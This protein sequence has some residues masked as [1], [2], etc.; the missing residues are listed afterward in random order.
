[1]SAQI[2]IQHD[3]QSRAYYRRK[4][5]EGKKHHG[6]VLALLGCLHVAADAD[7]TRPAC[8]ARRPRD[9]TGPLRPQRSRASRDPH[10]SRGPPRRPPARARSATGAARCANGW[11]GRRLATNRSCRR[12]CLT[13]SDRVEHLTIGGPKSRVPVP[14]APLGERSGDLTPSH[15]SRSSIASRPSSAPSARRIRDHEGGRRAPD[16]RRR[17]A[18]PRRDQPGVLRQ[19][20]CGAGVAAGLDRRRWRRWTWNRSSVVHVNYLP[21]PPQGDLSGL[22]EEGSRRARAHRAT[23]LQPRRVPGAAGHPAQTLAYGLPDSPIGQLA[24]IAEK[25]LAAMW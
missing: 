20:A 7:R 5:D 8:R 1:M 24:W 22:S 21:M 2:S 13:D 10:R 4:R 23:S 15:S 12:G 16:C 6:A 9:S 14:P 19:R 3:P 17:P 18:H 25:F 11:S